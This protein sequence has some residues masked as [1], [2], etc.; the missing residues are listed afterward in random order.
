MIIEHFEVRA[1]RVIK[2][3]AKNNPDLQKK[4]YLNFDEPE[5]T[6]Q[7]TYHLAT[8]REVFTGTACFGQASPPDVKKGFTD[9]VQAIDAM[10][11]GV[12]VISLRYGGWVASYYYN[13]DWKENMEQ[14]IRK[15]FPD[16]E[17]DFST[18]EGVIIANANQVY[19][20]N[21]MGVRIDVGPPAQS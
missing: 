5:G 12:A 9:V 3:R 6:L 14:D 11:K 2:E 17:I 7:S 18:V 8:I 16:A 13:P 20:T 15:Q 1:Q 10:K 19:A 4:V 21:F